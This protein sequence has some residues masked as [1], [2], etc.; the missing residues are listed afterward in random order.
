MQNLLKKYNFTCN[1]AQN[2]SN[3]RYPSGGVTFFKL[4][5]T[6][7]GSPWMPSSCQRSSISRI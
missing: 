1:P 6:P 5:I 2:L 7:F 4:S 3:E